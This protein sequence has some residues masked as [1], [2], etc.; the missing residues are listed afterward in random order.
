MLYTN[1]MYIHRYIQ[2][3]YCIL[4]SNTLLLASHTLYIISIS[5]NIITLYI[6]IIITLT[7]PIILVFEEQALMVLV[8]PLSTHCIRQEGEVDLRG[9]GLYQSPS[10]YLYDILLVLTENIT[11][12]IHCIRRIYV[13]MYMRVCIQVR[14]LRA[15]EQV[16]GK[17]ESTDALLYTYIEYRGL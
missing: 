15:P 1:S 10:V 9:S 5:P 14:Y 12:S 11:L 4:L 8:P 6:L 17:S 16:R 13:C 2:R 7:P 3:I